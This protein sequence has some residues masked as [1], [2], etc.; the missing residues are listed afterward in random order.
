MPRADI[1]QLLEK[2]HTLKEKIQLHLA[3]NHTL[4]AVQR[5][6]Q[7]IIR[8]QRAIKLLHQVLALMPRVMA[9]K[10]KMRQR[11]LRAIKQQQKQNF[12]MQKA[13]EQK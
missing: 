2:A 5:K 10:L 12:L 11:M 8:M 3:L 9:V 6:L 1:Q 4:K 7:A 13:L